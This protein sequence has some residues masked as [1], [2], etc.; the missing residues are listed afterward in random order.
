[1]IIS[2]HSWN[3]VNIFI[4]RSILWLGTPSKK[5]RVYPGALTNVPL[6]LAN[7]RDHLFF[8]IGSFCYKGSV[9]GGDFPRAVLSI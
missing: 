3:T 1:M 9:S 8:R 7:I 6:F 5:C 2:L 4:P